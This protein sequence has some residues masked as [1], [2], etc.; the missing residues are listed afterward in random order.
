MQSL[1]L[2]TSKVQL[3]AQKI[4]ANDTVLGKIIQIKCL[5]LEGT[6]EKFRRLVGIKEENVRRL[7]LMSY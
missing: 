2:N 5:E 3:V 4:E 7:M 6:Q 1:N